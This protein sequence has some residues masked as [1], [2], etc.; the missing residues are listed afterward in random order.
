MNDE[1]EKAQNEAAELNKGKLAMENTIKKL[2]KEVADG[3][4]PNT[5]A[6]TQVKQI[7]ARI[8]VLDGGFTL[9]QKKD[10]K[11]EWFADSEILTIQETLQTEF[12][13]R[14]QVNYNTCF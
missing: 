5:L 3:G 2:E 12:K 9:I 11:Q 14:Q 13:A 6:K 7:L 8:K 4:R 1:C 10:D